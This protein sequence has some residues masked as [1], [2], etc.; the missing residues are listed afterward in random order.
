MSEESSGSGKNKKQSW[1]PKDFLKEV[2]SFANTEGKQMVGFVRGKFR[3]AMEED[4]QVEEPVKETTEK[5]Q[6]V[7]VLPA[8]LLDALKS[9]ANVTGMSVAELIHN[10]VTRSLEEV[11]REE[12]EKKTEALSKLKLLKKEEESN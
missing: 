6:S 7:V 1:I 3:E 10:C 11:I 12:D 4:E 9:A 5:K 2:K 8:K